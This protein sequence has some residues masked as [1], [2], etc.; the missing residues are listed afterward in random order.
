MTRQ[1][2][3]AA[4]ATMMFALQASAATFLVPSGGTGATGIITDLGRYEAG[5]YLLSGSGVAAFLGGEDGV[6]LPDGRPALAVTNPQYLNFNFDGSFDDNGVFGVAGSRV[7]LG[8]LIGTL[9]ATP[10]GPDDWFLIGNQ[11]SI[12]LADSG[13]IYASVNDTYYD[14]NIGAFGVTVQ[15]VPEPAEYLMLCA[16]LILFALL[17]KYRRDFP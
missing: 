15:S 6:G 13:H 3:A 1:L 2:F 4:A 11:A 14:N 9:S 16:G 10:A 8:A 17:S 12:A 5:S 7:R